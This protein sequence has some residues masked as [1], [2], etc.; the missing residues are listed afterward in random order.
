MPSK[1]SELT[2]D[3]SNNEK[4]NNSSPQSFSKRQNP[5]NSPKFSLQTPSSQSSNSRKA[6][7]LLKNN[8]INEET[9]NLDNMS[10]SSIQ[11]N[12]NTNQKQNFA[13][14]PNK[15]RKISTDEQNSINKSGFLKRMM[16]WF[17]QYKGPPSLRLSQNPIQSFL[18]LH[19][20]IDESFGSKILF[21]TDEYFGYASNLLKNTP[22]L[23]NDNSEE[24][25]SKDGWV[26]KRRRELGH[27]WCV[28]E[29]GL[30]GEIYGFEIN[31][32]NLDLD[33]T[34][35]LSIEATFCPNLCE[36]HFKLLSNDNKQ[37]DNNLYSNFIKIDKQIEDVLHSYN[38][39]WIELVDPDEANFT[40][41]KN[42]EIIYLIV[43]DP[44]LRI[45]FTH[46]RINLFP[47]GGISRIKTF[48][49]PNF[50]NKN[51]LN[52]EILNV[53]SPYYGTCLLLFQYNSLLKGHPKDIINP[54]IRDTKWETKRNPNRYPIIF[55]PFPYDSN[56]GDWAVYKLGFRSIIDELKISYI[57]CE[58]STPQKIIVQGLDLEKSI[59]E[60]YL[61]EQKWFQNE[62]NRGRSNSN[63]RILSEFLIQND[64]QTNINLVKNLP[65]WTKRTATHI[66]LILMP[67]GAISNFIVLGSKVK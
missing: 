9:V 35:R 5:Q 30:S 39:D 45:N 55:S 13:N 10:S 33:K 15:L 56:E 17:T 6:S 50:S 16:K 20:L 48:G 63:W 47:D 31:L 34:P 59:S 23:I 26:T 21:A 41:I 29:M 19:N 52:Q 36:K 37:N 64:N 43:E 44:E 61:E 27:D 32:K 60:D 46:L 57:G 51:N 67:D 3:N 12:E 7:S 22:P 65:H 42:I 4:S 14:Q 25:K 11:S 28:I 62:I 54:S 66:R 53:I 40:E 18:N 2:N 49:K 1:K 58:G 8:K 24:P 38:T